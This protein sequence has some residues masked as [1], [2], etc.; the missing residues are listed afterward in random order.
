MYL[1]LIALY[2][3]IETE[4]VDVESVAEPTI[5]AA[6][7]LPTGAEVPHDKPAAKCDNAAKRGRGRPSGPR[8]DPRKSQEHAVD[9]LRN[10]LFSNEL[11]NEQSSTKQT[12]RKAQAN[13]GDAAAKKRKQPVEDKQREQSAV[14]FAGFAESLLN[15][16]EPSDEYLSNMVISSGSAE[17]SA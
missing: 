6:V 10:I 8:I 7:Q 12:K 14:E 5:T 17:P 4:N 16:S 3:Y 2:L 13:G 15:N 1:L 11:R 9:I